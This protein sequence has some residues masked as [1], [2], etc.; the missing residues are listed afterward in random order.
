MPPPAPGSHGDALRLPTLELSAAGAADT[1]TAETA[2][3]SKQT[4]PVL[5]CRTSRTSLCFVSARGQP[6]RSNV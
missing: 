5:P 6:G 3:A 1:S 2:C 4:A